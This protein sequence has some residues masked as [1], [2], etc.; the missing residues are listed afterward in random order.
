MTGL[1]YC[2]YFHDTNYNIV[3]DMTTL[4]YCNYSHDTNYKIVNEAVTRLQYCNTAIT[5]LSMKP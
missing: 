5:I 2:N 4:Q 3:N 1:Q